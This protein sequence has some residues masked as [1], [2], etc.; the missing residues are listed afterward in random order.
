MLLRCTYA[1]EFRLGLVAAEKDQESANQWQHG[2]HQEPGGPEILAGVAGTLGLYHEALA[3][4]AQ[5]DDGAVPL[6]VGA[7]VQ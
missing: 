3:G 1:G 4:I 7:P 2:E 5:L 6:A